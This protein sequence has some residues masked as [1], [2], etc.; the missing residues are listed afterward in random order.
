MF[1]RAL[2]CL[3]LVTVTTATAADRPNVLMICVDDLKPLL[4]CYGDPLAKTPHIDRFAQRALRF[5][6]A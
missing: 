4:G 5:D 1:V 6:R 3:W 2:T